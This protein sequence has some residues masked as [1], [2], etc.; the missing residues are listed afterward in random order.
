MRKARIVGVAAVALM[1]WAA[2]C[3]AQ[4]LANIRPLQSFA[5]IPPLAQT[6]ADVRAR[7]GDVVGPDGKTGG[8]DTRAQPVLKRLSDWITA[9]NQQAM[10][11][12][13]GAQ[14]MNPQAMMGMTA[15]GGQLI[16]KLQMSSMQLN[17]DQRQLTMS[18]GQAKQQLEQKYQDDISNIEASF[19]KR[20]DE[21]G[22]LDPGKTT[23]DCAAV[24]KEQDVA[25]LKAGDTFLSNLAAPYADM[26]AKNKAIA[27]QA[28][29]L[30]D[31]AHKTFGANVPFM[32]NAMMQQL[33]TLG[34]VSLSAVV[35]TESDAVAH[36]HTQSIEP[37]EHK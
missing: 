30:L 26:A 23:I 19:R 16:G 7:F 37:T 4:G 3:R 25:T 6:S 12:A 9:L 20:L 22:C 10:S 28:Q 11:Q 34:I 27:T 21:G 32:A 17:T 31:E 36:V 24:R 5:D 35:I 14:A 13:G 2:P 15:A 1:P 29:G 33:T 18:F 8:G